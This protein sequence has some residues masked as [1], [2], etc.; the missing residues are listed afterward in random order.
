MPEKTT[1]PKKILIE[2]AA[3]HPLKDGR[4]P[5]EEFQIR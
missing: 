5:G 2:V 3:Q 4:E 1:K